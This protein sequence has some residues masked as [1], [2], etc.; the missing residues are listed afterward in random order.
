MSSI[1]KAGNSTNP[2]SVASDGSGGLIIRVGEE[3]NLI[4]ALTISADGT[5]TLVKT[6]NIKF[7]AVAV[8]SADPNTL[9]DYEEGVWTP[10]FTL[11]VPGTS[12]FTYSVQAGRY[13]KVGNMVTAW[14]H[15]AT[16][17]ASAGTGSG[18]LAASGLPFAPA[19]GVIYSSGVVGY[20]SGFTTKAPASV[21]VGDGANYANFYTPNG[22]NFD[23]IYAANI[24]AA[25][26][27]YFTLSYRA[28]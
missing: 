17:A 15:I 25:M 14:G 9:D 19:S 21:M 4:D 12:S 27:V 7:P 28:A 10:S 16:S 1:L 26:D 23:A 11:A 8:P 5:I 22:P 3:N 20:A 13:T 24:G 2:L 6:G 18:I